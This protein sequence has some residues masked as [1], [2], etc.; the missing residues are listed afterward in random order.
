MARKP[1]K[2]PKTYRRSPVTMQDWGPE[3]A[4]VFRIAG[5][6]WKPPTQVKVSHLQRGWTLVGKF[7]TPK[8]DIATLRVGLRRY[9][10]GS[11]GFTEETMSF[12]FF[13]P[14]GRKS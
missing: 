7:E 4:P 1:A 12:R 2:R 8:G 13:G 10:D 14:S 3:M 6:D 5:E 11:L 9:A